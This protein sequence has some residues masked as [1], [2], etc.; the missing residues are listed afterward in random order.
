MSVLGDTDDQNL[1]FGR[2]ARTEQKIFITP[3]LILVF[4]GIMDKIQIW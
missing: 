2:M 1:W 3:L 4:L